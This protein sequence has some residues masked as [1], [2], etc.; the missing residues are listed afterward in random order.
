[1]PPLLAF[2]NIK[3]ALQATTTSNSSWGT[4]LNNN[5]RR[6]SNNCALNSFNVD[7]L[8]ECQE[9]IGKFN[10]GQLDYFTLTMTGESGLHLN[11]AQPSSGT[12]SSEWWSEMTSSRLGEEQVTFV[13]CEVNY[14]S[15]S[16]SVSRSKTVMLRWTPDN[17]KI[18]QKMLS[19]AFAKTIRSNLAALGA[20]IFVVVEAGSKDEV[21]H[22][23]VVSKVTSRCTVK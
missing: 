22:D 23:Y 12:S 1:M 9:A 6:M 19:A 8:S 2:I 15:Q 14:V 7:N 18:K 5:T 16:D 11:H 20:N 17:A 3:P 13:V 10:K 4:T 21:D